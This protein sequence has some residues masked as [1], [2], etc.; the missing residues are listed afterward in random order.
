MA[1]TARQMETSQATI[2]CCIEID[3]QSGCILQEIDEHIW[4]TFRT[5]KMKSCIAIIGPDIQI[6]A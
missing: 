1:M 4:I 3:A 2:V 6:N 5:Y